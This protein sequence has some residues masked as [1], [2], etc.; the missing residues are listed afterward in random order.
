MNQE[1]IGK[2]IQERRKIKKLTQEELAEKLGVN[3]RSISRWENGKCMP[4]LSILKDLSK[5]LDI[6]INDL[7]NG[8]IVDKEKYQ[9]T[10]EE[11]TINL[12][13]Y[14]KN[15][16]DKLLSIF[17]ILIN[18]IFITSIIIIVLFLLLVVNAKC[19]IKEEYNSRIMNVFNDKDLVFEIASKEGTLSQIAR[20]IEIN[21]EKITY[22]F[23]TWNY[24]IL[25]KIQNNINDNYGNNKTYL[26]DNNISSKFKVYYTLENFDDIISSSEKELENIIKTSN[27][28]YEE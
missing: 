11:N 25:E 21:N 10:F 18:S 6:T 1:K 19:L 24:T 20:T 28:M 4:D 17:K 23:V 16:K 14:I 22:I 5:E 26:N 7:L 8:E 27:L 15:H 13:C 3:N 12:L 2:F 9:E